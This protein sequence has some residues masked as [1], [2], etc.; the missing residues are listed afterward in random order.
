VYES[1]ELCRDVDRYLIGELVHEDAALAEARNSSA[2]TVMPRA[3]GPGGKVV[4]LS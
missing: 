1:E 4:T 2:Q 3:V